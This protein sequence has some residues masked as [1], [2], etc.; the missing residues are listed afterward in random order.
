MKNA[1]ENFWETILAVC[2][3]V[4]TA[5]VLLQ[6]LVRYVIQTSVPAVEEVVSLSFIYT[7]FLGAAIGVKRADHLNIDILVRHF[8]PRCR[9]G[10]NLAVAVATALFLVF[11]VKEG[12][13]FVQDSYTQTTTYLNMPMSYSYAAIPGSALLMLYYLG[14]QF[15]RSVQSGGAPAAAEGGHH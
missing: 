2:V 4:L 6:V 11:V 7:I 14:K 8:P 1:L 12:V 13:A 3:V 5:S 15:Y 10:L 9:H